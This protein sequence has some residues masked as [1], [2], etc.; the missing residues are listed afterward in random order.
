MFIR[1]E[2]RGNSSAFCCIF[3]PNRLFQRFFR[4]LPKNCRNPCID[5]QENG[6]TLGKDGIRDPIIDL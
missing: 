5:P 1:R 4:K 6:S 2:K 3:T